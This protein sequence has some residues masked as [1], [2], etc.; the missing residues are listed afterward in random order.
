MEYKPLIFNNRFER[1]N[2]LKS[3]FT[4]IIGE[5]AVGTLISGGFLT[6][7]ASTKFHGAYEGGL[8]DHS[9]NVAYILFELTENN[10]LQWQSKDRSPW[11]VGLLH[12]LCKIDQYKPIL[13]ETG[14]VIPNRYEWNN[15]PIVRGH[16]MKSVIYAQGMGIRLNE[17]DRACMI[18]HMG[19]F[20]PE[21]EWQD[22]THAVNIYP[23]VLWTHQ[24]DMIVSHIMEV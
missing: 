16:G 12:D 24:A 4:K 10:N 9:I 5:L 23:N 21:K 19:A 22:Y 13:N 3:N 7:P 17:E 18:Y 11:V 6:A 14:D 8:F 20:T 15:N 1:E 2:F